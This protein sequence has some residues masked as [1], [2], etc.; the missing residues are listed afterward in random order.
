MR[1]VGRP[2]KASLLHEALRISMVQRHG[3]PLR[4]A[5]LPSSQAVDVVRRCAAEG[6]RP[7]CV[8]TETAGL[9]TVPQAIERADLAGGRVLF[10]FGAEDIGVPLEVAEQCADFV[11]IPT[12]GKGSLNVSHA[13]AVALYERSRQ[14]RM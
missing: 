5:A 8:E 3:W 4:I 12:S 9:R 2:G 6:I 10:V 1:G 11:S 7:I 13:V 14:L